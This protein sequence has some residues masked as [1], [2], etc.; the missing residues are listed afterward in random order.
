[1]RAFTYQELNKTL[2]E[3]CRERDKIQAQMDDNNLSINEAQRLSKEILEKEDEDFKV[4][5]PR[6]VVDLHKV[7]LEQFNETQLNLERQNSRLTIEKNKLDRII[8]VLELVIEES[9][10][11]EGSISDKDSEEG[12]NKEDENREDN[13]D[14]SNAD[15]NDEDS[16]ED[17]NKNTIADQSEKDINTDSN[18]ISEQIKMFKHK[19][20]L[21]S[22]FIGQDPVRAKR[23]L[24]KISRD[25][26]KMLL[27]LKK[28][29]R[30]K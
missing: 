23:E 24:E 5:S 22:K 3:L 15:Q 14:V 28:V 16:K 27:K 12:E 7:E 2:R 25:M 11:G 18:I 29:S 13:E 17:D 20:E 9:K 4:F 10:E 19:I 30:E 8:G 21:S 26:D 6:K 1:M